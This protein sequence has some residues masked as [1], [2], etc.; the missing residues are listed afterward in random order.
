MGRDYG[1]TTCRSAQNTSQHWYEIET[2]MPGGPSKVYSEE[3]YKLRV[4]TGPGGQNAIK[5]AFGARNIILS[6]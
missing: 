3:L 4:C 6:S 1:F 5:T 2:S